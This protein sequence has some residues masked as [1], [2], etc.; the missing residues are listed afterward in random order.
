MLRIPVKTVSPSKTTGSTGS[1]VP[2]TSLERVD[3]QEDE[4]PVPGVPDVQACII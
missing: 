4:S 2:E 3:E 1:A